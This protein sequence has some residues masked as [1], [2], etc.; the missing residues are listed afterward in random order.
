MSYRSLILRLSVFTMLVSVFACKQNKQEASAPEETT[1]EAVDTFNWNPENFADVKIIRYQVP[2]F[3][4]LTLQ[5]KKLVYYLVQAGLAGRDIIYDQNYRHNLAI[6]RALE[7]IIND[8]KGER[9]GTDWDGLM[10]YAK[11]VW[12]A[13]GI[14]HHY[15]NDKFNPGFS[16]EYFKGL[17]T[18]VGAQLSDD[19]L[20][21]MFDPHYDVKKV[22][23]SSGKDIVKASAVNFYDSDITKKEVDDFYARQRATLKDDKISYGI[24]SKIVRG[25]GKQVEERVWKAD[26]M[27]GPAIQE[28]IKWLDKAVGVAENQAQG[29]ALRL[30][31]DYYKTGSLKTWDDYNIAWSKATEGDIDYINGF[32]ETYKDPL[33]RKGTYE[34]IVQINDFDASSR[35]KVVSD[36]AQWFEDN[37]PVLPQHKKKEVKGVTYKMVMVAGEAGD[38]SPS[39]PIG[40]N[41]PNAD[42]I[43]ADYGS[44]SVSLGNI[45]EAYSKADGPGLLKEF[46]NDQEEIDRAIKYGDVASKMHTALHEVLGHASGQLEKGVNTDVLEVYYSPLEEGR[47]DLFALYYIMD[48]KL[49]ELGLVE[50][51]EVGKAAYDQYLRN[52]LML[53]LRRILPG[54]DIEE[55][56]MRNRQFVSEWV[57]EKGKAAGV[58][59]MVKRDGKTYIDIKDYQKLRELFGE[60][61]REVQRIK[62]QGDYAACEKLIEDYGVKV[63][64]AIHAEVL[65]RSEGLHVPPYGGF[66]NPRLVP[67]TDTNGEITDVKVEYPADFVQ[68]MLEYGRNYSFLP[69]KN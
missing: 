13:S 58:V 30:L 8:Y 48:P 35:M 28:I 62:S 24:N 25:A 59:E 68:Q 40:V 34:T 20:K 17:L 56:H 52:G 55:A 44:K 10:L 47:A 49:V 65:Q 60:L 33:G 15:S 26:G 61:L 50:S 38:A 54:K 4:K 69:D 66:I 23:Q 18:A 21:A 12:F 14:H 41:L 36:N 42:W 11:E 2:G 19:A 37:S 31:I 32:V 3:D 1:A 43:R 53:Q 51:D 39:T 57:F 29:D 6:R 7:K 5:Q 22:D 64:Q 16:Q 27:Y 9:S 67:V 45:I 46:A 63:D